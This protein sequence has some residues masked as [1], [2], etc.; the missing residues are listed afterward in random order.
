MDVSIPPPDPATFWSMV[1]AFPT[2]MTAPVVRTWRKI[3][4]VE[5]NYVSKEEIVII[6]SKHEAESR[7]RSETIRRDIARIEAAMAALNSFL[8]EHKR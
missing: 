7:E 2:V 5:R 3:N 8:L 6:M 1:I 4:H